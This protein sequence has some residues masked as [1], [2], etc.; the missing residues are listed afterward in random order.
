[1][2]GLVD[3]QLQSWDKPQ[4]CPPNLEI[5]KLATYYQYEENT[6]CRLIG[7]H[8]TEL[9][10]YDKIYIFSESKDFVK[11]PD[12][13]R[14]ATNVVFGGT[15]FTNDIYTPFENKLIDYTIARTDIYKPLMKERYATGLKEKEIDCLLDSSYYRWHA[16][17]ETL[18]IPPIYKRKRI[19]IYDKDFFQ[20]GWR[21]ILNRITKRKPAA[22]YF[23]HPL[24]FT[25]ISDFLDVREQSLIA[26]SHDTY[27][28][29]NIPLKETP[30]LMKHYKNRLLA[31]I[32]Q[33]AQVYISLGGSYHYKSDYFR[34]IIY[35]LNLLYVFWS[36]GIPLKIKY[37]EP[38][39]G[40]YDPI[41]DISKLI[42]TWSQGE[43][44]NYKSIIDR[45]PK[46]KKLTE[47]RPEREQLRTILKYYPSYETLFRQTT[48]TTQKGG[49][50]KY[51][52]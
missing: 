33:S 42:A 45:I 4:L 34:N 22:I 15:A 6:F 20:E 49:L 1:M 44:C 3:L 23:I 29:L 5:M 50:W 51:G 14:R 2:I 18:P 32:N 37:E 7:L 28:D 11:V 16:G 27:L 36:C 17:E 10:N 26:R 48:E 25:K 35:K 40:C 30:I 8:E 43:T 24:H 12:A 19:Y 9:T 13:F 31:V 21:I 52:Y 38:S 47:I 41:P 39:I 46:D